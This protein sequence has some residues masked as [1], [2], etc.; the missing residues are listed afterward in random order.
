MGL[1]YKNIIGIILY[2]VYH[3]KNNRILICILF[4]KLFLSL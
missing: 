1:Y 3:T 4:Y 2:M